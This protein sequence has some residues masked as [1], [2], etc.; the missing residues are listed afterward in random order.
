MKQIY[1]C[2]PAGKFK[3]L[4]LS[5]DDG[6]HADRRL[7]G[8]LNQAGIK[9]TFH[10]N[11]GFLG[12]DGMVTAEEAWSLY[13]GHE[14]ASHSLTHPNLTRCSKEQIT[15]QILEDRKR[16]ED[17]TGYAVRGFSYPY[18]AWTREI[19]SLL[20]PLGIEYAR[21]VETTGA[22]WMS[23]DLLAWKTTC[24]HN[25]DLLGHTRR[26]LELSGRHHLYWFSVWGH[27]YE[28]DT[29]GN[30]NI[31][32][33]FSGTI[34]SQKDIWHTTVIGMVDYLQAARGI[35]MAVTGD[36]V[37]NPASQPVWLT[38]DGAVVEIPAGSVVTL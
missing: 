21:L 16:L 4:S 10:L 17:I 20:P 18:G 3:A 6:R 25:Q 29:Q 5:Y 27:S 9:G 15:H 24:H 11:S 8:I 14:V 31:I 33:E 37:E 23:D 36:F 7:V 28:F 26:F 30:W 19:A 34:G 22:F 32:E 35:R 38:V 2:F 1:T 12:N 13:Q